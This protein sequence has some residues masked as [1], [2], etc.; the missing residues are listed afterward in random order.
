VAAQRIVR[1]AQPARLRLIEE[2]RSGGKPGG[3]FF[4]SFLL[5]HKE[6]D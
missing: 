1:V 2:P 4:G 5:P 6:R 3:F